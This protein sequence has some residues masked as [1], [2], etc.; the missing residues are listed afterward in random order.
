MDFKT[1][2]HSGPQ[3]LLIVWAGFGTLSLWSRSW[4][5]E[6]VSFR[7]GRFQAEGLELNS[8][9]LCLHTPA[10]NV[11]PSAQEVNTAQL[12]RNVLELV[13]AG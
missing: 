3:Q 10:G 7:T 1:T 11:P 9:L 6:S 4:S 13:S 5:K 12:L 8:R 2:W